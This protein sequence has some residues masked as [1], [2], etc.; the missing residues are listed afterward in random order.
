VTLLAYLP[1]LR[2]DFVHDDRGQILANPAL[3]SWQAVP[4]YFTAHVWSAVAPAFLGNDYRPLFLLWLRLNAAV[5]GFHPAGWHFTTIV[6]HLAATYAVIRLAA[7]I[8]RDWPTALASGLIFGLH[9]V[10]FEAVAWISGL[11]EPLAA[12][13]L[14]TAYLG[15]LR[16]REEGRSRWLGASLILYALALLTKET[17]VVLLPILLASCWLGFPSSP[18]APADGWRRKSVQAG[19]ALLPFA[20]L[21]VAYLL[22]RAVALKGFSHPAEHISLLTTALTWPSLLLFYLRLLV[23]PVGLSP[24]YGLNFVVHP[25][26]ANTVMPLAV[27]LGVAAGMA[28]WAQRARPVALAIPW[29]ILP[30]LPVL[31]VQVFG[32]GNF[33]H[34]RYL[35]LPSVGF[36][37]LVALAL[38]ALKRGRPLLGAIPRMQAAVCLGLALLLGVATVRE[39]RYYASDV[40]FYSYAY[41]HGRTDDPIIG[42]DY[43]SALAEQGDY[44]RAAAIYRAVL[45]AHPDMWN[46][47]F[48]L[49]YMYYQRGDLAAAAEWLS[50]ASR[51]QPGNGAAAFYLG[52]ADLKLNRLEEAEANLRRA[53]VLA[54]AAPNY[55]FALGVVLKLRGDWAGA[56]AAFTRELE[57][58]PGLESAARQAAE[59]RARRTQK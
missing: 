57:I 47:C 17:A 54:P 41:A 25:S 12:V 34:N 11:P 51:G 26:F 18:E 27:L 44:D 22:A 53:A 36:A 24:F 2:F 21:T 32:N 15:W 16:F 29:L 19:R 23:W 45:Q 3:R 39:D 13:F 55:H 33:A 49:G 7:R 8:C 14:L 59:I 30:V 20:V 46:A 1:T 5:F 6:A 52:L 40:A 48:N 28:R 31:D 56:L 37:L 38:G 9:P 4:G 42:M 10:H 58:S 35:Y 43:A 50:R